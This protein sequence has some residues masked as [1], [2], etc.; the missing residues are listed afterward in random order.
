MNNKENTSFFNLS[1]LGGSWRRGNLWLFL[2]LIVITIV[3]WIVFDP[4]IV[5]LYYYS[6]PMGYDH[7][8]LIYAE[9]TDN[10]WPDNPNEQT[11]DHIRTQ[12]TSQFESFEEVENV[13]F[14]KSSFSQIGINDGAC[15]TVSSG[16]DTMYLAHIDFYPDIHFFETYGLKPLPGSPKAEE[17]SKLA[18]IGRQAVLTRKAAESLFGTTDVL[19]RHFK[20]VDKEKGDCDV[21]VA[22][23][24][25]NIRTSVSANMQSIMFVPEKLLWY[26]IRFII[27]LKKNVNPQHFIAEHGREVKAK[28]KTEDWRITKLTTFDEFL[29]QKELEKGN[30]QE[31]NRSLA[32]AL[33]FLLNLCLAVIGTVWLQAKCRTEECGVRRAY[34]ATK[35]RLMLSFLAEGALMATIAVIIGCFIFLNYAYSGYIPGTSYGKD[36]FNAMYYTCYFTP[37]QDQTW[38]DHFWPHFLIVSAVVY[39]IILCTVLIGTA[40]PAFKIINNKITE[41]L[42]DNS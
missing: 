20:H 1:P 4:A 18:E 33:F 27:R 21:T 32:M 24:V 35:L 16:K 29:Q 31:V 34:G 25:E 2:E 39:L 36:C 28:G 9:A 17:L 37:L 41:A 15:Y 13:Y 11:W 22:G 10:I 30:T 3:A 6:L 12:A 40:I 42:H 14:Y 38:V 8:Q 5:N 26:D 7:E 23:V 19:G